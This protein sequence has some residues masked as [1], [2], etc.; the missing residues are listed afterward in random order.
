MKKGSY[1]IEAQ[2]AIQRQ[3]SLYA[4]FALLLIVVRA[5]S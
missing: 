5:A 2:L 1:L 4:L 3:F